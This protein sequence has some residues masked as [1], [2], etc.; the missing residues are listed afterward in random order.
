MR[1]ITRFLIFVIEKEYVTKKAKHR[2][3]KI[4]IEGNKQP[5]KRNKQIS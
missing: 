2:T 5:I 3:W 1:V 4:R